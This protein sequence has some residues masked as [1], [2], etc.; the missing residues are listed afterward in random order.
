MRFSRMARHGIA[1]VSEARRGTCRG[2][3]ASGRHGALQ[4]V[5]Y[6]LTGRPLAWMD[7]HRAWGRVATECEA[8]IADRASFIAIRASTP[9][10][11]AADRT[12]ERRP[13]AA[14]AAPRHPDRRAAGPGLRRAHR[15]DGGAAAVPRRVPVA[16]P[17]HRDALSPVPTR[18]VDSCGSLAVDA[19]ASDGGLQAFL[20]VFPSRGARST[21]QRP[22]S[23]F[24]HTFG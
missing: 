15:P 10:R 23:R 13:D 21:E 20:A 22:R 18:R 7:A 2:G 16:G 19:L 17:R 1:S 4:R 11:L 5:L 3:S 8:L 12:P 9:T 14:G 6:Q 24:L